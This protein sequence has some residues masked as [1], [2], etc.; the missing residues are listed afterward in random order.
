MDGRVRRVKG[1]HCRSPEMRLGISTNRL[2]RTCS[3]CA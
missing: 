1:D 2:W 3:S